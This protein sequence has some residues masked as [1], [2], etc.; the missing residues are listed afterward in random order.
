MASNQPNNGEQDEQLAKQTSK[1]SMSAK[2]P[3]FTPKAAPFIPSFQ[4]PGFVPVNNIAGGYPYAQYTGQGQNSNSPHPTKSYQQYYQKPTG[5]TVDE[6]K[7][8][9]P[10]FSKKKSFVPPKPAIPKGKVLSLGGNTSAPKSTKPISISLGGTKAP[11]T[12]KPAAPAAQSKTETPAP[13]VTSESTKKETAAPPPQETPTKSADAELAKTPSAP[14]AA[15]KKAAEAAEPATV[16]ED[17]TDLQNEVDQELLKDMYGKEHVN[18]V[19]IGHVDA[20]KSTLGGN[21]LFLTGMVDKRTMEKI[22]REAKE[23]G[24]ES[25]YLSWALDSTSEEREKGKTVEVGRAYFETEHRRFSLLDAPGHKGYVTNMIN[26]ASQADIGVLVISARRG[27]FEAGFERGGQTREHAVLARTQ[28]INHLV[29]VINK[30]DEPSVQWSEERYKECVDKLSMFL[31]RVAG[32]NSKTDVKYMPVSAYT[33]QNVKDRV[34][35]SVCPWYQGPS[36]LEYLDSMTH[37]ERKVN[38]PFIMPIASKYKDL[39]TIL[40]GKIEA[41]SI[42]K[43][44]NVLVMPINQTLEVTAIYDEADEEIS[45]S[46]C[47]DQVRL[48][49]RGDDSDVQTGYVLTST[50]NPVHATT[51]FIAQIAILELPSILTTGYSCVMHIHTA[52]EEVSFAK[53]LHKLDKTNRKS[54]KPPMFATKGMKIIAELETQTPVCM[55]RFEDYQYMGRF[56]LRDQGTTV[57]VGKV[58]KI[59]D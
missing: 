47:G 54:K 44:S 21:I 55:E 12:T 8:R 28:G 19:F 3:T 35:S 9:V 4:R 53:L 27:E 52:V 26:G 29:V 15:L 59:L 23:A 32:Y 6:D 40:E 50:K 24:K 34:D 16:T 2:A 20:G 18:I 13:K 31:R 14:A 11:T 33:G 36:L 30:M 43:N 46:I 7:S 5:N 37:L 56:T 25:W 42:K 48:R 49:V 58:V 17:A 41:G 45:S 38:A 51:R 39:G 57:A 22:E 10:D 1:L